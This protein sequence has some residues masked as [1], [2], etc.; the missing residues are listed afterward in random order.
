MT[1]SNLVPTA[2]AQHLR[3]HPLRHDFNSNLD[4]IN[5]LFKFTD[6]PLN[7]VRNLIDNK[8][9]LC[10]TRSPEAKDVQVTFH[11]SQARDSIQQKVPFYYALQ[12]FGQRAHA[13]RFNPDNTFTRSSSPRPIPSLDEIL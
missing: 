8:S 7:A 13:V 10:L 3:Q 5:N 12:G 2:W 6:G 11:H 4:A 9:L 1:D